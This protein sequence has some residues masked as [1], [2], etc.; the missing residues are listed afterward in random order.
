MKV[1]PKRESL[2]LLNEGTNK[3]ETWEHLTLYD[4]EGQILIKSE[5]NHPE[6][7]EIRVEYDGLVYVATRSGDVF[8]TYQSLLNKFQ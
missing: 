4:K 3:D 8:V 1:Y 7:S 5:R 2:T 6:N